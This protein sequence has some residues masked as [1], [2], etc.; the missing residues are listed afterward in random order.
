M[1][2]MKKMAISKE[3]ILLVIAVTL[4]YLNSCGGTRYLTDEYANGPKQF[5]RSNNS[6]LHQDGV[7]EL[8]TSGLKDCDHACQIDSQCICEGMTRCTD[9][10]C[11]ACPKLGSRCYAFFQNCCPGDTC[12]F[13]VGTCIKNPIHQL[14]KVIK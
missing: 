1:M 10:K 2:K 6:N 8:A 3:L 9:R 14:F 4:M 5:P 12:T 11:V 13:L 7:V